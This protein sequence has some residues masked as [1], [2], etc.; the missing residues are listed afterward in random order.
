MWWNRKKK[1]IDEL[2]PEK[3]A[4]G[5][6]P[7]EEIN[8]ENQQVWFVI[9]TPASFQGPMFVDSTLTT[10]NKMEEI[11]FSRGYWAALKDEYASVRYYFARIG[12][13]SF[14]ELKPEI[15]GREATFKD[16]DIQQ[17]ETL[18]LIK[19]FFYKL[20][21]SVKYF[22]I[23][24]DGEE[25]PQI[26]IFDANGNCVD[27]ASSVWARIM[28]IGT[29]SEVQIIMHNTNSPIVIAGTNAQEGYYAVKAEKFYS[30]DENSKIVDKETLYL[31]AANNGNAS[32][33]F[34]LGILYSEKNEY[35]K[36]VE[37]F[38]KAAE[39]GVAQAWYSLGI[40][41]NNGK[42]VAINKTEAEKC[43][44]KAAEQG[45]VEAQ[46]NLAVLYE[47]R[48]RYDVAIEWHKKAAEQSFGQSQYNLGV[49]YANLNNF[50][51]AVKWYKLAVEQSHSEAQC[52]LALCYNNG[53]GV[54]KNQTEAK[55]L[56]IL[57]AEQ[58]NVIAQNNL[59][60]FYYNEENIDEAF[61]WCC[62]AFKNGYDY[63]KI[64]MDNITK[65]IDEI[66]IT[67]MSENEINNPHLFCELGMAFEN[68]TD[69]KNAEICFVKAAVQLD[70]LDG[71][72]LLGLFYFQQNKEDKAAKWYKIAADKGHPWAQCN[73]ANIYMHNQSYDD[74][75]K[76]FTLAANQ[77]D[78]IAK[79]NLMLC[80]TLKN[81]DEETRNK[82]NLQTNIIDGK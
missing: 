38:Q 69:L 23:S 32:A 11:M 31:K 77:G 15:D 1:K 61:E 80:S 9:R 43:Y 14:V 33:Q 2:P 67:K 76:Y 46:Y 24:K 45:I 64:N 53:N 55:R 68:Q 3:S 22:T 66:I 82:I 74:A 16:Y 57:A 30:D 6:N 27:A 60:G 21:Y 49:I 20:P 62:K 34:N 70:N 72:Y 75:E 42:G 19:E 63:A 78:E 12:Y 13:D 52:N 41:Y 58:N 26:E 36:A 39:Q 25:I 35:K 59:G 29:T 37:W 50:K 44:T 8:N 54:E 10:I 4:E 48:K 17:G 7:L 65:H 81:L 5:I 51:E 71:Q 40:I 73:L 56:M 28:V 18:Y 47:E 79:T